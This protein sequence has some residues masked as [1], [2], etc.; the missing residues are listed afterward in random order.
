MLRRVA[1]GLAA[2]PDPAWPHAE[3]GVRLRRAEETETLS[4]RTVVE[5][6][7]ES[8]LAP[9]GGSSQSAAAPNAPNASPPSGPVTP[10]VVADA[11][12]GQA[13]PNRPATT[14]GPGG[15]LSP[16]P[17]STEAHT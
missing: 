3:Q 7:A 8:R 1:G 10:S 17:K 11:P 16:Q 4:Y 15:E 14:A 2:Q 5:R 6:N 12:I 13:C 9:S